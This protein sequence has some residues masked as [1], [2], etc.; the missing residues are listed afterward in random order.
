MD[1]KELHIQAVKD[2]TRRLELA[3]EEMESAAIARRDAL[4]AAIQ[5]GVSVAELSRRLKVSRAAL[6]STLNK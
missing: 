1:E 6:Y 4:R 3:A 5:A 2:A